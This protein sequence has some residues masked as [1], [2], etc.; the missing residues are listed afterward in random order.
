[1]VCTPQDQAG[2]AQGED[3]VGEENEGGAV[4]ALK[5]VTNMCAEAWDAVVTIVALVCMAWVWYL[6]GEQSRGARA[7][8]GGFSGCLSRVCG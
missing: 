5:G 2:V 1:M 7:I 4:W 3:P 8:V 6:Y